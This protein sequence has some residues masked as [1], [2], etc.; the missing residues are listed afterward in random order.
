MF[1]AILRLQWR[2]SRLALLVLAAVGAS[3]PLASLRGVESQGDAWRAFRILD[4]S[5][6]WAPSYPLLALGLALVLAAG[7]WIADHRS[8]HVYALTLPIARWRYL[9]FRYAAGGILLLAI[10]AVLYA[11]GLLATSR[12]SLPPMLHAYPA[13]LT[14]RFCL[15]G[16]SAYTVLFAL[17]GIT[18]RTA[19]LLVAGI[20]LLITV[21][22]LADLLS[23]DWHPLV[24]LGDAVLGPYSPL[25]IFRARWMLIDV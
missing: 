15:A 4:A 18:P 16:L 22:A 8:R 9:L 13:G 21:A 2:E 1:R 10:G 23:L 6:V 17:N 19:R 24:A 3:L 20:L 14:V 12:I 7:A 5:A 11:A 25:A